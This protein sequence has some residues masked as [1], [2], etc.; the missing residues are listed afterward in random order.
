MQSF[1]LSPKEP[2]SGG[3]I[4]Q[5][6][7]VFH[8]PTA[9][10]SALG[11]GQWGAGPTAVGLKRESGWTYGML[12]NHIWSYAGWRDQD[13]SATFL[14]PFVTLRQAA[15]SRPDSRQRRQANRLGTDG[16]E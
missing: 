2:T 6:G 3:W 9:T 1:F 10:D 8:W 14:Q 7:P 11:A 4:W 13:H 5:A 12:A 16:E 15:E